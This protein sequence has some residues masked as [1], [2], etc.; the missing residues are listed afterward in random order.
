MPNLRGVGEEGDSTQ[1][2]AQN[3]KERGK[4]RRN[5]R[6]KSNG[7]VLRIFTRGFRLLVSPDAQQNVLQF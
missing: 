6:K 7:I 5:E 3:L 1:T 2:S 4:L